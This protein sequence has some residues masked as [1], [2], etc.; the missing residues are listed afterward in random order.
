VIETATAPPD[1]VQVGGRMDR[2]LQLY[3]NSPT[4]GVAPNPVSKAKSD[5]RIFL[6][7]DG[8]MAQTAF[9]LLIPHCCTTGP[10]LHTLLRLGE[11]LDPQS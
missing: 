5:I 1:A 9:H 4:C 11:V 10:L 2:Q 3:R 8:A 6:S 7:V